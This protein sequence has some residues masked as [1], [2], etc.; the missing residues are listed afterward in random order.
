MKNS[1]F[2]SERIADEIDNSSDAEIFINTSDNCKFLILRA[3]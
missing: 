1:P 3:L 2:D